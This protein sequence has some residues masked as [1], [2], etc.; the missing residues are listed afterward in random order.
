VLQELGEFFDE[1][2]GEE[3]KENED[4]DAEDDGDAEDDNDAGD[5]DD[6]ED[7]DDAEGGPR[8][9]TRSLVTSQSLQA[10]SAQSQ[11]V[12]V[13]KGKKTTVLTKLIVS[14]A[15]GVSIQAMT[16]CHDRFLLWMR[17]IDAKS[18]QQNQE[19]PIK[20]TAEN[21]IAIPNFFFHQIIKISRVG[22]LASLIFYYSYHP[23]GEAD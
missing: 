3:D 2:N 14:I 8:P 22:H 11:T 16:A 6:A 18:R 23:K 17:K 5:N 15:E 9:L 4:L 13:K 12:T 20:F 10:V 19:L 21:M 7:D 1:E